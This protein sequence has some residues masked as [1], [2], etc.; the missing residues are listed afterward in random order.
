MNRRALEKAILNAPI[1]I[2]KT[3]TD[4]FAPL[5]AVLGW[6]DLIDLINQGCLLIPPFQRQNVWN[7]KREAG[8]LNFM[9]SGIAPLAAIYTAAPEEEDLINYSVFP[10]RTPLNMEQL[11]DGQLVSLIDGLQRVS[12]FYK[13][14]TGQLNEVYFDLINF[15][16]LSYAGKQKSTHV[17]VQWFLDPDIFWHE[18]IITDLPAN[19]ASTP[20]L[21]EA[22]VRCRHKLFSYTFTNYWCNGLCLGRQQGLFVNLNQSPMVISQVIMNTSFISSQG[23][24]WFKFT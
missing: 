18:R 21:R 9:L 7:S 20:E 8:L 16:F 14:I 23:F 4:G 19:Y 13:A 3:K 2:E 10:D 15:C 17:K 24:N 12:T 5:P 6:N 22:L 11:P 1:A